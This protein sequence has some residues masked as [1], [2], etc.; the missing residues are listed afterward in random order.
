[1]TINKYL[2]EV[3]KKFP[4]QSAELPNNKLTRLNKQ[5]EYLMKLFTDYGGAE[6]LDAI[7]TLTIRIK[8]SR[9]EIN[10][11]YNY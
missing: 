11:V 4:Q 8:D 6:L 10:Y 5:K 7:S 2:V 1:M 9:Q 3:G